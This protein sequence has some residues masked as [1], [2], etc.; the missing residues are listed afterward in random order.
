M[1][2]LSC[3]YLEKIDDNHKKREVMYKLI[4]GTVFVQ[5]NQV[6]HPSV[7]VSDKLKMKMEQYCEL[8][9]CMYR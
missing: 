4:K 8:G 5:P 2:Y 6:F 7:E 3:N 1:L 9:D